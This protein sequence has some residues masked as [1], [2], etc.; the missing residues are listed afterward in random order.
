MEYL[1]AWGTLIHEKNL[2]SNISCQTPF[3]EKFVVVIG[4]SKVTIS[5]ITIGLADTVENPRC[6]RR[7][8]TRRSF[9][10]RP[11]LGSQIANQQNAKI[12]GMQIANP[13][14]A[15]FLGGPQIYF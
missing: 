13:Q 8:G 2:S 1:W 15:T 6:N 11:W 9:Q 4:E 7:L 14:I 3:N 5:Q 12:Y 10:A